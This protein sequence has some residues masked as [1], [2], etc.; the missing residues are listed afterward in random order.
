MVL[1]DGG[2][3]WTRRK[4]LAAGAIGSAV[5]LAG[6][7]ARPPAVPAPAGGPGFPVTITDRFGPVTVAAPPSRIASVGRTDHDVLLALGIVPASVYRFVPTMT[8]GVGVWAEARLGSATPEILTAPLQLERIAALRPDL[9]LDVQSA[10]DETEYRALSRIAPTIGLPPGSAPNTVSWQD[11][12]RIISRAVGRAADGERLVAETDAVLDRA[13][14]ANPEFAGRT[15]S[16]LLSS[17]ATL[18][19]YTTTDS[20]MQVVTA[21]GLRPSTYA[22]GLDPRRFFV[23]LSP[24]LVDTADADVVLVL[25][26][27]GLSRSATLA[28]HP[29]L[30]ASRAAT[31]GRLVV[32]ESVDVT[33]A[34]SAGSVLSI[35]FAVEGLVPLIRTAL[36]Q[37]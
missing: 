18:G 26:R 22:A 21:L 32:V 19:G 31:Q 28:R 7:G 35:P 10:G 1:V 29:A 13:A 5:A 17:G 4:A 15:V 25:T 37:R 24:E 12:T 14:A 2:G 9:I 23:E 6:C 30:A 36:G 11:C 8:K 3:R 33:L 16:I 20:R 34:L 27:E